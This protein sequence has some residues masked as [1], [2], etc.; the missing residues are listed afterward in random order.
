MSGY[1]LESR[2]SVEK[3]LRKS[4]DAKL[5]KRLAGMREYD[6]ASHRPV[7]GELLYEFSGN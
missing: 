5:Q 7:S 2:P 3:M 4:R 1:W 6:N